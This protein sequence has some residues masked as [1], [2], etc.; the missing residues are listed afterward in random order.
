M[1]QLVAAFAASGIEDPV[2]DARLLVCAAA[3]IT[4]ADLVRDPDLELVDMAARR[5]EAYAARRIAR[6]PVSRI[7]GSRGF[8]DLDLLVT[9]AVLDP[10]PD[11][12]TL[13]EAALEVFAERRM[14][15]LRIVDLGTGSGA[16]LCAL[17]REFPA[18]T[19]VGIDLSAAACEVAR[20]N[21]ARCGLAGRGEIQHGEWGEAMGRRFDLAVANPPY[22]AS[23]IIC[24]LAPEVRDH[25]PRLALDGGADGLHAYRALA[26]LLPRILAG[27]GLAVLE[28]GAEQSESVR[29]LL[30]NAGL[31][32][33][34][35]RRDLAGCARAIVAFAP[36]AGDETA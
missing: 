4:H 24:T 8:W 7:L 34:A 2:L 9:P 21:L 17:L 33:A 20:L 15:A 29:A 5:L 1:R 28:T 12:E 14:S 30:H 22:I 6:E 18:A 35:P 23:E 16:L 19:G 11:T 3:Q 32:V 13:V 10:R 27:A 31:T 26:S 36:P 25:D